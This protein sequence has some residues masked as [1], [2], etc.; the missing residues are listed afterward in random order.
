LVHRRARAKRDL[1]EHYVYLAE[2]AGMETA[3]RFLVNAD[4]SFGDLSR[5]PEMGARL[6]FRTP[7][8]DR[9]TQMGG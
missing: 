3:E 9:V 6:A 8:A 4:K 7:K 1:F 5:H 2:H